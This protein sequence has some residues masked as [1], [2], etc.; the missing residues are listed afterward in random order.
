MESQW[1]GRYLHETRGG[2]GCTSW[3]GSIV[4]SGSLGVAKN[5]LRARFLRHKRGLIGPQG[6]HRR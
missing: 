5:H 4:F 6:E 2:M 3:A 1:A